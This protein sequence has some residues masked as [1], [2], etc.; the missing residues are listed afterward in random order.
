MSTSWSKPR[1]YLLLFLLLPVVVF[2]SVGEGGQ[3]SSTNVALL[4]FYV[5]LSLVASFICSISE[6][7]LLTMTPS[8][9]E[10][11][12]ED[13]PKT[14]ELL[15]DIKVHNIEKSISS[16]L[17]LNTVAHTLGSLGAGA[18]A[19][20]VFGSAWFGV[21]S[22]VMTVVIL[23][24][25]EIIPKTL[26]TTYWRKF[27]VPVAYYVKGINILLFPM[28]W[29][30]ERISRLMTKGNHE[31]DFNRSEFI[32][33]ANQGESLGQMSE[34]ETRIIKNSLAL[35]MIHVESIVTPRSVMVAF[36]ENMTVGDVFATHA[37]LPF[38]RFPIFDED[39]DNATG[40]VLKT[41]LLIA[42]ANREIH[43]PIKAFKREIT[44]VF[45]KMKLFDVLD[46]MLKERFHIALVVGEFG[47]VK[48][49]VSLEDVLETLLGLEIVDEIDR[50]DDMQ[51][52]A[53]QLMDRR[54]NRLGTKV[55]DDENVNEVPNPNENQ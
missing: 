4:I 39:L 29:F 43:M 26:G 8:Y 36:D 7:T 5:S 37:K 17:T 38:S 44:F 16:I 46:L 23:I 54:M 14:A 41:D 9:I 22:A 25:T 24:G 51:A 15:E 12:K 6:A 32:A 53:R 2:A 35:S 27:S 45:A 1:F 31:S 11:I 48:G 10:S 13:N 19:T 34:L 55:A 40:F 30:A 33:L 52:L 49:I 3:A 47:E 50:V 28:V 18:Q 21:F 42:K 20:V